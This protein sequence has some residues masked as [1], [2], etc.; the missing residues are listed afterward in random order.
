M[1]MLCTLAQVKTL[2]N[3]PAEDT[4]QDDKLTLLI[5]SASAKIEGYLGYSLQRASYTE[6]VHSVNNRQLIHLNH[7][8][9]QS[10][11]S[12]TVREVPIEDYKL[13]PEYTRWGNLYRGDGWSGT[14]YTRG[15]THDIVSGAW[16]VNVSYVA[17]Y[18][19]PN[20][21]GYVE[22][23][24][25]SL[26]YDILTVCLEMVELKYNFEKMGATGLKSHSEGHISETY[27][28]DSYSVGLSAGAKDI[29]DCYKFYGVA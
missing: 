1:S 8:P 2:L 12:V 15:F 16:E 24:E 22:G 3:I 27:G 20:D 11:A 5:K 14:Y 10:V 9:I 7:F 6:E 17:G 21:I 29:L 4:T 23:S 19:L 26:P 18:Y 28:D 13:F 25:S